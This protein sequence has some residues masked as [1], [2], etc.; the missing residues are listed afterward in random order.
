MKICKTLTILLVSLISM[1]VFADRCPFCNTPDKHNYYF[2]NYLDCVSAHSMYPISPE[3]MVE[4]CEAQMA[5]I[6]S[7]DPEEFDSGTGQTISGTTE[8][9]P[10]PLRKK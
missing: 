7:L 8:N 9:C 2:D 1:P 5:C 4:I 6:G 10:L 3:M